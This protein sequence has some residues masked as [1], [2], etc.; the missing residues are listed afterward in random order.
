MVYSCQ[1]ERLTLLLQLAFDVRKY[2]S[3]GKELSLVSVV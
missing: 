1:A 2:L 3:N